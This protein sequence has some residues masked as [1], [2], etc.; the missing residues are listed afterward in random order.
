MKRNIVFVIFIKNMSENYHEWLNIGYL[1]SNLRIDDINTH[2]I[3]Y[4][5]DDIKN[6]VT[7]AL[8]HSPDIIG[9]PVLQYNYSAI[10]KFSYEVK[11]ESPKV[12]ITCGNILPTIY[13]SR[14]LH[15]NRYVDSIT[16]GEGENSFSELCQLILDGKPLSFCK[17][18]IYRNENKEIIENPPREEILNL[19]TL[20]FPDRTFTKKGNHICGII[21]S[22]GCEG[23]CT[24]CEANVVFSGKTR[25]R[26]IDNILD[27]VAVLL[28][29][30]CK[31][32]S[33]YDSTFCVD[34][35]D[36]VIR[37]NQLYTKIAE[38]AYRFNFSMNIRSEQ[39][40]DELVSLLLKLKS[41]GLDRIF[42]GFESGN[43]DDL[44]L[45]GK[46]ASV[47]DH[48]KTIELC[49][50]NHIIDG[51]NGIT[52]NYGF[53]NFNPYSTIA[54][55]RQ[56]IDFLDKNKLFVTFDILK[57]RLRIS[58]GTPI[59]KKMRKDKLLLCNDEDILIDAFAYDYCDKS[60][61]KLYNVTDYC[62]EKFNI[63]D[64][65]RLL[66]IYYRYEKM[67]H[68]RDEDAL[69]DFIFFKTQVSNFCIETFRWLLYNHQE[70][71]TYLVYKIEK[72]IRSFND[73]FDIYNKK[74][75]AFQNK[76]CIELY[77]KGELLIL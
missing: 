52:F 7:E 59:T 36:T 76:L 54:K 31:Y 62:A 35:S 21:G 46:P 26:S 67:H 75:H 34:K 47:L 72:D 11:K 58:D 64:F 5:V 70:E 14:F 12:H 30:G 37:L 74:A 71:E 20:A 56:N 49:R 69:K 51:L 16:V 77:K 41:V 66:S 3:F 29:N 60:I 44:K 55:L 50:K 33:F 2:V 25:S 17:G 65:D 68:S 10:K 23:H 6:A 73:K 1:I 24:F 63:R 32:V 53:I 48:H 8:S 27:E 40:S 4:K 57:T 42:V 9:I 18:I 13:K 43:E 19:D 45:Y 61:E 15:A 39:F 28:K 22:R 38:R